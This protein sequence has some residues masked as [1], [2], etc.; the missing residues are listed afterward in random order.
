M[1]SEIKSALASD[2]QLPA[3]LRRQAVDRIC[4]LERE[5]ASTQ[6]ELRVLRSAIANDAHAASFQSLGQY[7]TS[8]LQTTFTGT[9]NEIV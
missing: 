6:R 8:L 2:E 5:I 3:E 9:N 7:R 4:H 1:T